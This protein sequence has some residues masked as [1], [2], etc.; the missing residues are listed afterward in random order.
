VEFAPGFSGVVDAAIFGVVAAAEVGDRV[1]RASCVAGNPACRR[2]FRPP[3]PIRDEFL[4]LEQRPLA[5][6]EAESRAEARGPLWGWLKPA[7]RGGQSL[8]A[9]IARPR[10]EESRRCRHERGSTRRAVS[11]ASNHSATRVVTGECLHVGNGRQECL[12]HVDGPRSSSRIGNGGLKRRLQAGL[13]A[14]PR[15]PNVHQ[16]HSSPKASSA[17]LDKLKHVLPK[18]ADS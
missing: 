3:F 8:E 14:P 15:R 11:S 2:P 12:R 4:G 5:G 16:K 18:R 1:R 17:R 7:P 10:R 13:P 6:E 9:S